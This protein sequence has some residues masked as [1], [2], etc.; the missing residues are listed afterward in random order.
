[1]PGLQPNGGGA[2]QRFA[3]F[4]VVLVGSADAAGCCLNW[5]V[6]GSRIF[7][8][9]A[10]SLAAGFLVSTFVAVCFTAA[11]VAAGLLGC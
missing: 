6:T 8:F 9:A 11:S 7:R 4:F 1:M 2:G 3:G 5:P 10:F